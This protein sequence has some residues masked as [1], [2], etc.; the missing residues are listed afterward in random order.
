MA[1]FFY[2]FIFRL[3][4]AKSTRIPKFSSN[5]GR[6]GTACAV[7]REIWRRLLKKRIKE[8]YR[9]RCSARGSFLESESF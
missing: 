6:K 5:K 2:V 8:K 7:S 9:K 1:V 4:Q 3:F